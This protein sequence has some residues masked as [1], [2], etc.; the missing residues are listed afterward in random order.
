MD[1]TVNP[2]NTLR[3]VDALIKENKDFEMFVLPKSTHGFFNESEDFFEHKMWRHFA[4]MLL[5]DYSADTNVDL[6][7]DMINDNRR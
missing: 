5:H 4:R 6:N 3:L 7:K 2:A 1:K